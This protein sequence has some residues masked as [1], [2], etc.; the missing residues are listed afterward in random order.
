MLWKTFIF[1]ICIQLVLTMQRCFSLA[2]NALTVRNQK[3]GWIGSRKKEIATLC[4]INFQMKFYFKQSWVQISPMLV[5]WSR[6]LKWLRII[7]RVHSANLILKNLFLDCLAKEH[8]DLVLSNILQE[9]KEKF[10]YYY[11]L[12]CVWMLPPESTNSL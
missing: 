6:C 11:F 3:E 4:S 12:T 7:S 1:N 10:Y 8:I 2:N 5:H 9:R